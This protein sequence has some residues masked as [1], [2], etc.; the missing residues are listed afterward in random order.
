MRA[1]SVAVV[2]LNAASPSGTPLPDPAPKSDATLQPGDM[3]A[4]MPWVR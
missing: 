1:P 4:V 3:S 2:R